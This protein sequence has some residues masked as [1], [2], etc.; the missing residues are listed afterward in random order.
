SRVD[1]GFLVRTTGG[2]R[3]FLPCGNVR[4]AVPSG[5]CGARYGP[6]YDG[7]RHRHP[8]TALK[9][10]GTMTRWPLIAAIVAL[11]LV[12]GPACRSTGVPRARPGTTVRPASPTGHR[13]TAGPPTCVQLVF[14]G[15]TLQ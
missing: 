12:G 15:L 13:P 14:R 11:V 4:S 2:L 7:P 3:A 5:R 9:A 10:A 1:R 8:E 6:S